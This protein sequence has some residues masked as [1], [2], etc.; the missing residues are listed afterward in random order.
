MK[1]WYFVLIAFA[2]AQISL[3]LVSILTLEPLADA[4]YERGRQVQ[5]VANALKTTVDPGQRIELIDSSR[6][7]HSKADRY[8]VKLYSMQVLICLITGAISATAIVGFEKN[9]CA[10]EPSKN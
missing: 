10:C 7:A 5:I 9:R 2:T 1:R 6:P 4:S 8:L 3:S